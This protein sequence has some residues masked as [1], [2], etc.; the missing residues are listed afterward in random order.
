LVALLAV[1]SRQDVSDEEMQRSLSQQMSSTETTLRASQRKFQEDTGR[2]QDLIS[3]Q[4]ILDDFQGKALQAETSSGLAQPLLEAVVGMDDRCQAGVCL[5]QAEADLAPVA[6][7]ARFDIANFRPLPTG[8]RAGQML[9]S[10][11]GKRCFYALGG[12]L[13]FLME[14]GLTEA[15]KRDLQNE[16]IEQLLVRAR[17]IVR[18]L[19]Q[20][21]DLAALLKEK[22]Q[23]LV[24]LADSQ[25]Q[26][27]QSEKLA[28]IGQLAAG[29]AHEINSP[30][31]A[32]HLQA[33]MARRRLQK[34]DHEGV[35]RSLETCQQA[36]L[37]AKTIIESLLAYS[38][39]SDG[40]RQP[41]LLEEVVNQTT[42][43]LEA[44][45]EEAKV[46]VKVKLGKLA[47]VIGNAGELGQILTNILIN[48]VD[49]LK[50]RESDRRIMISAQAVA[51]EQRLTIANNGPLLPDEVLERLF[52]PFF[53]TKEVGSGTGLG[54][55]I[56]YQLA[57]GHGGSVLA[58][59]SKEW[60]HFTLVLPSP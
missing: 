21:H 44:H 54:L 4:Q 10:Q 17:L 23:A 1:Y 24:Q 18:I 58:S 43:M 52:D 37:R 51:A 45:F 34:N 56:A 12:G 5:A 28:A 49:A 32:I 27:L 11:D 42:R 60:V 31:A 30:L 19:E 20:K 47:P 13:F 48:A 36:S 55:S 8:W 35:L 41:V 3:L 57:Q 14:S 15:E 50:E 26:L 46:V 53:T 33:Q 39:F 25:A 9:R 22:T 29:V 59:N 6:G 7:S 2:F 38:Q 16:F 40:A